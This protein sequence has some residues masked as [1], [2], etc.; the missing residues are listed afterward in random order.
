MSK[1]TAATTKTHLGFLLNNFGPNQLAFRVIDSGNKILESNA[2]TLDVVGFFCDPAPPVTFSSFATL[3]MAESYKYNGHLVAT[4]LRTADR[5]IRMAN[6]GRKFFFI[7][8]LE[9][10]KPQYRNNYLG[11]KEL[12]RHPKLELLVR[13]KS[14]QDLIRLC[15]GRETTV[16]DEAYL[17]EDI[18]GLINGKKERNNG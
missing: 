16:I 9:W 15:W 11:I 5:L 1:T 6:A 18:W 2:K 10:L 8:D 14:H 12:Y 4:D 3:N 7:N 17:I 13:S